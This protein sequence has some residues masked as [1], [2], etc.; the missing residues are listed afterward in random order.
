MDNSSIGTSRMLK[1][2]RQPP[3]DSMPRALSE[4]DSSNA[5]TNGEGLILELDKSIKCR[6]LN[7]KNAQANGIK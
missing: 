5:I 3:K 2:I 1:N 6:F 4:M 7:K